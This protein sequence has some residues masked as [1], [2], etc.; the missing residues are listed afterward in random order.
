MR[1]HRVYF[2]ELS[3]DTNEVV[4]S[5]KAAIHLIRVLRVKPGHQLILFDGRGSEYQATV[6]TIVRKTVMASIQHR[7]IISRESPLTITLIQ[8]ISRGERMDWLLQKATELGVS[9]IIPIYTKRSVVALDTKRLPSRMLHWQGIIASACEQCG[10]NTLPVLSQPITLPEVVARQPATNCYYLDPEST[11]RLG[12]IG[13]SDNIS[14]IIG[15]EGGFETEEKELMNKGGITS[16]AMGP[17]ILRTETAGI[18]AIAAISA[19][20][21]DL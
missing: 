13:K 11:R 14:F 6:T 1:I 2:P 12:M 20:W 10:R 3:A 19:L 15:P 21:G 7:K 18:T 16:L 5:D 4:I 9:H 8:G 17:R